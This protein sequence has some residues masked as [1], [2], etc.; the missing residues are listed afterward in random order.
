MRQ[1][2]HKNIFSSFG[3]HKIE[4]KTALVRNGSFFLMN[5]ELQFESHKSTEILKFNILTKFD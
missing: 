5:F 4:Q 3:I 2:K 1:K